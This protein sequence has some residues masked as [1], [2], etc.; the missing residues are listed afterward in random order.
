MTAAESE[1]WTLS[2]LVDD[3]LAR[4]P[5]LKFYEAEIAAAKAGR[6]SA[7]AV[8]NPELTVG[9]GYKGVRDGSGQLLGE[10]AAW[11][12]S[13][14]QP[15]DWPGRLSLRKAIADRQVNLAEL[16]LAQFRATL[17]LRAGSLGYTMLAAQ[18][19]AAAAQEIAE[20]FT[21]LREVLV[22]RE[23]AGVA[24]ELEIR[25]LE[26]TALMQ[27]RGATDAA[28]EA[29]KALV[30]LNLLR[31][32]PADSPLTLSG[33]LPPLPS[34]RPLVDLVASTRT[35]SFA[36]RARAVE[37]EQQGFKVS[38]A[39]NER[40]PAVTLAPYVSQER[41]GDRETQ[42]GLSLSFPLG[43]NS[44]ARNREE[45]ER[46]RLAQAEASLAATQREVERQVV[47]AAM[48]YEVKRAELTRW[49]GDPAAQ[50]RAHADLADRHYRLG[51]V[52]IATYLEAQKTFLEV[53]GAVTDTRREAW[54]A[55]LELETLAGPTGAKERP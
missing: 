47:E 54:E 43:L 34:P 51:A 44:T 19:R 22:Q 1:S 8:A 23:P 31:G 9:G 46:A 20:R 5:E 18:Q 29:R 39:H 40:K 27:Q 37:L 52:P 32:L 33:D 15:I 41:A 6:R 12:V 10:G 24:P 21:T 16:G 36:V 53:L 13:V 42:A 50:F 55:W 35:N 30:A 49:S 38:L 48:R 25:I 2:A 26:G 14:A 3:T 17:R 45:T 4:N 7:G 11:S 28:V